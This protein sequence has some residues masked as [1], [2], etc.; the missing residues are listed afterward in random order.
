MDASRSTSLEVLIAAVAR[1]DRAA[2]ADLY[3]ATSP[4]L[5]A[6]ALRILKRRD[7]AEE[8]LQ[9][10]Y[11]S[12]WR[13]AGDYRPA[14]GSAFAWMA[15]IVRYRAID[16]VRRDRALVPLDDAPERAT[17]A[18]PGPSPFDAASASAEARRLKA[19]L[20]SLE[21]KPRAAIMMAYYEGLT[22]EELAGRLATPL[23]TVKSW[24]R[25]G[26]AK[27]KECLGP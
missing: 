26:L 3:A 20:D 24:I 25:R 27:L 21:E 11:V 7:R 19:C 8:A 22:H 16:L 4:Q 10:A 17:W 14:R 6:V 12:L 13:R 2:F 9:D 18:D 5:F 15:S 1:G 23:G